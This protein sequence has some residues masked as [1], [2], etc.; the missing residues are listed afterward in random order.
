MAVAYVSQ[1]RV[2]PG[3]SQ[4]ATGL[5]RE[6]KQIATRLGAAVRV[7]NA[8][9]AG[10]DTFIR[11]FVMEVEDLEAW[12]RLAQ[13]LSTDAEWLTFQPKLFNAQ[14]PMTLISNSVLNEVRLE[15]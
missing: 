11:S 4:E 6:A 10:P 5:F 15:G 8:L 13:S 14:A 2:A 1:W 9:A 3:R 7:Y 12:G